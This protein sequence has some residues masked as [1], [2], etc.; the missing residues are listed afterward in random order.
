VLALAAAG[1][2]VLAGRLMFSAF[3]FYDDEGYVLM[4]LQNF[5][6]HGGLYGEV[7]SQY[8]PF[9]FT[10]WL[11]LHT[12]GVPVNHLAGRLVTLSVWL[13][14]ALGCALL[15][16]HV[17]RSLPAALATLAATFPYLWIMVSEPSHPGSLVALSVAL[18]AV[19]GSHALVSG[20]LT[21]WATVTGG[22]AAAAALTKINVGAFLVC[23]GLAWILLHHGSATVAR[24]A[25]AAVAA[26]IVLL[27]LALMRPMLGLPW[28][29]AFAAI[30]VL[31]ALAAL[32]AADDTP[33]PGV[34][35]RTL[36]RCVAAGAAVA[37][38]IVLPPLL[39][40]TTPAGL[41]EGILLGPLRHPAAFNLSY[42]WPAGSLGLAVGSLVAAVVAR[43][44]A[45]GGSRAVHAWVAVFRLAAAAGVAAT[46]LRFPAASP[47]RWVFGFGAPLLWLFVW[48]LPGETDAARRTATWLALLWLGQYLH[49]FPVAGSQVAWGTFLA[50]PLAAIGAWS[51]LHWFRDH[52]PVAPAL[53]TP[54]AARAAAALALV[55]AVA[56]SARF[57]AGAERY[58]DGSDLALPG[59]DFL[60]LPESA[61]ALFRILATNA[62][63]HGDVLFS[64]PGMFSLNLWTGLPT[65]TLANVTHWFSL[66]DADRQHA[67]VRALERAPR[68]V[69]VVQR[70]HIEYLTKR[71]FAPSG[72]LHDYIAA[73]FVP[74][75]QLDNFE[76]CIRRGRTIDPL[77]LGEMQVYGPAAGQPNTA[78][79]LRLPLAPGQT[80]ARI[81][82][83]SPVQPQRPALRLDAGNARATAVPTDPQGRPTAGARD[84]A[85]P[86]AADAGSALLVHFDRFAQIAPLEG[87]VIR[88]YDAAGRE[89]ALG[90]L[91]R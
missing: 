13:A 52:P 22:A 39:R 10:G 29:Q 56:F 71:S 11:A 1:L 51:A 83:T 21:L 34:D 50:V 67:I 69:V 2:A 59:T 72:P 68:A 80:V 48:R 66:L 27:P 62:V 36:G 24:R 86:F 55:A 60:R 70:E 25:P 33:V 81:E 43:R 89:V 44:A 79:R 47:D 26:G 74:A 16:R 23:S 54:A 3:M 4:S 42:T 84:L 5:A 82:L 8:G 19:V 41:L 40:G 57:R 37:L 18:A 64:Q 7:Y 35:W 61:T 17:T 32:A 38:A 77:L 75:F 20:R 73:H 46:V 76:F 14:I 85:W 45:R 6:A 91:L 58:R 15:V 65:P 28:V 31:A 90:R 87:S 88:C 30:F 9:P 53:R 63:A 49:A 12:L 78:L